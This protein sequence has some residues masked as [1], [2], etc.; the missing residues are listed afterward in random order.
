[1]DVIPLLNKCSQT[2]KKMQLGNLYMSLM[3]LKIKGSRI[4]ASAAGMPPILIYRS[5]QR[6]VEAV[7]IKGLPLGGPAGATY[8][9]VHEDILPGD[10]VLL[11]SDGF[12]ELFDDDMEMLDYSR[13]KELF[14]ETAERSPEEI[15]SHLRK[16]AEQWLNGKAQDD[17]ITFVA[18]KCKGVSQ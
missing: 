2:I 7:A 10:T 14:E 13:A 17:D 3:L 6:R 12:P 5:Q 18:L 1:M 9:E 16:A 15:I 8:K 4:T 11:M